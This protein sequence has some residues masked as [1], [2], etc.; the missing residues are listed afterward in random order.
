L[1][2]HAD[3]ILEPMR[4]TA[5]KGSADPQWQ[6]IFWDEALDTIAHKMRDIAAQGGAEQTAFSVITSSGIHISDAI[7]WIQRLKGNRLVPKSTLVVLAGDR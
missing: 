5:P 3:R 7:S 6:V 2:Y 1:V 4:R